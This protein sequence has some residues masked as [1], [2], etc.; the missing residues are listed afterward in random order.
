MNRC[1]LMRKEPCG[2]SDLNFGHVT[3]VPPTL[4]PFS[5]RRPC[6]K[7]YIHMAAESKTKDS[8]KLEKMSLLVLG[9]CIAALVYLVV[10][11]PF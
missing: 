2:N 3:A 8:L 10:Y 7:L 1:S 5:T 4:G 6:L 9:L 11:R